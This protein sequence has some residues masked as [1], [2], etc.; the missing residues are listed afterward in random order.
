MPIPTEEKH[1]M[2][3]PKPSTRVLV[4]KILAESPKTTDA[5]LAKA[6]GVSR[7][8]IL[9][10]RTSGR[11]GPLPQP[12][13]QPPKVAP[14]KIVETYLR[15]RHLR[16]TALELGISPSVARKALTRAKIPVPKSRKELDPITAKL[17]TLV[18]A[19]PPVLVRD[20]A[21]TCGLTYL[22]AH[23][24]LKKAHLIVPP[25]PLP[26]DEEI[27]A[28][29]LAGAHV[30]EI[31]DYYGVS[32]WTIVRS[33]KKTGTPR[34]ETNASRAMVRARRVHM[35][36]NSAR[37]EHI[38]DDPKALAETLPHKEK[39]DLVMATYPAVEED[40]DNLPPHLRKMLTDTEEVG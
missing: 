35:M 38:L 2:P 3:D 1:T 14:E 25:D 33:L 11:E 13:Y 32:K 19:E 21:V 17:V 18:R 4:F 12:P 26:N 30:S 31:G 9:Q 37:M 24:R 27:A 20:A 39:M 8:R 28:R 16:A 7:Q 22:G 5:Q 23:K 10:I 6:L 29:Y 15:L 40:E 34:R 36:P